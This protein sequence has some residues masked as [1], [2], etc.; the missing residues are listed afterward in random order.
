[1]ASGLAGPVAI[2]ITQLIPAPID[3][4]WRRIT[5][6]ERLGDWMLEASD[7]VVLSDQ[8]EGVGVEAEAT[9]RIAG[10]TTRDKVRVSVWE[11]PRRLVIDHLGWVSGSGDMALVPYG[12]ETFLYWREELVP[13]LG[14]LGRLGLLTFAPVMKRIFA[15]DAKILASLAGQM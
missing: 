6:W 12:A 13:P 5:D 10:I 2:E 9:V 1:M 11:P 3:E 8:R 14:A 4:V 15:R 7:F